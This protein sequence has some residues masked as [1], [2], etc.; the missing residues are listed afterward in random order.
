MVSSWIT[1]SKLV[2]RAA[3]LVLL[4]GCGMGTDSKPP[5][6]VSPSSNVSPVALAGLQLGY[7]W[8]SGQH[9]LYPILGVSGASHYGGAALSGGAHI[10]NAAAT[11]S[12][13][14]ASI[15]VLRQDG[16]L[17]EWELPAA[18]TSTL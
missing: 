14:S 7:I 12:P 2:L 10:V 9:N 6:P 17:Q 13:S 5:Q 3:L 15:L 16:T 8:Q 1:S 4:T 18:T 11:A